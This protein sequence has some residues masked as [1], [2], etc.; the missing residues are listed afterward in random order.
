MPYTD[1]PW[2]LWAAPAL[3]LFVAL[4]VLW[5]YRRRARR[6]RRLATNELLPRLV[7]PASARAPWVRALLQFGAVLC[8]GVAFAGPR[9]GTEQTLERGSGVDIVLALDASLSMLATDARPNRLERMKEEARR[10]L[11]LSGGDRVGLLAFAGRSYIL[12]PLTVDRGALELFLDNLDPS[13]VG[14]AGSSLSRA[15]RQG[16]DLL[17]ATQTTSDR[18]LIVMSD[19]EAFEPADEITAAAAHAAEAGVTVIAVGFGT[20]KGATIPVRTAQGTQAKR[21]E[22]GQIVTTRYTP[23]LLKDAVTA[24][25]GV[26]ID[27][28]ATDKASR[29]RG[30]L[31]MLRRQARETE[32]ETARRARFQLF[33]IP[34]LL[35]VLLDSV[36]S[37][38]R[39]RSRRAPAAATAT[40]LALALLVVPATLRAETGDTGDKLYQAAR[41]PEAAAAYQREIQEHADSPRLEYNLGTALMQSG[42]LDEAVTAL[43]RAATTATSEDL[44]YSALYN[45][46]LCYLRQARDAKSGEA[47]NAYASSAEAYKRALQLRPGEVA[48]KWNYELASQEKSK[49]SGGGGSQQPQNQKQQ[50][51]E[52]QQQ[53]GS[54]DKRQAEQLLS[55]AQREERDV[56]AKKQ[57]E[58]QPERPPAGKDW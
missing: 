40:A 48:A 24:A 21:D 12:T 16:T 43:E 25:H 9:W 46:G 36:L 35:L 19:G 57:R 2:A 55:S 58:N 38:R 1:V 27:A 23:E 54:L 32:S 7:P 28:A 10:L 42:Q 14:Q 45:L 56:Q 34:A 6:L 4:L 18:A 52:K 33:L 49:L 15:I 5:S 30:A 8:A 13:V 51:Q 31:A 22:N 3:A 39:G 17:V 26:F 44:R 41:Y 53:P 11:A 29:I 37:T 20:E 50:Q 47:T